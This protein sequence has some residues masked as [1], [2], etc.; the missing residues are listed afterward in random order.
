MT[1]SLQDVSDAM[2]EIDFCTLAT[3]T[4]DGS[5]GSRPMSNNRNVD[6]EGD[7]WFFTYENRQMI[8]DI[9]QNPNVGVTY[10]DSPGAMG[11]FGKP[12]MFIHVEGH[13][14]LI[15]DKAA[16]KAHWEPA[17]DRWF[18]EGVDTPGLMLIQVTARRIHY[19][20]GMDEGEVEL[21]HATA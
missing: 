6:Y 19:W 17:L 13:A 10:M 18:K 5:I 11:L 9:E 8:R 7:A 12:G 16:F 3:R 15:A 2:R 20:D 4:A 21:E 1:K 14:K